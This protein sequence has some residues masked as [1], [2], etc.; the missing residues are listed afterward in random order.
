MTPEIRFLRVADRQSKISRICGAIHEHYSRGDRILVR[1]ADERAAEYIDKLLWLYPKESF[2]PHE[3]AYA[4]TDAHVVI[5]TADRNLNEATILVHLASETSAML[6]RFKVVYD[7]KDETS[8]A[9]HSQAERR[10]QSYHRA[11][12]A[13]SVM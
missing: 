8:Q 13:V 7:L 12:H 4:P 10:W 9:K 2:L 6:P 5:T 1:V 11:K 3:I